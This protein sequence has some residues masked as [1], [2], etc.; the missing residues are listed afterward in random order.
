MPST[1]NSRLWRASAT[2][3]FAAAALTACSGGN[4]LAPTPVPSPPV[5]PPP[6][7]PPTGDTFDIDG[8]VTK[9]TVLGGAVRI[10]DPAAPETVLATGETSETDGSYDVVIPADANFS[11]DF[12]KVIVTGQDGAEMV[13][14]AAIG[15]ADAAFGETFPIDASFSLSAL[16]PAPGDGESDT[17]YVSALTDLAAAL[18]ESNAADGE[19]ST[20]LLGNA[21]QQVA[22]IFGLVSGDLTDLVPVDITGA[23]SDADPVRLRAALLN[24]GILAAAFEGDGDLGAVFDGLRTEFTDRGGQLIIN[25]ESDDPDVVSLRDILE[26]ASAAGGEVAFSSSAL[27]EARSGVQ[28]D[29]ATARASRPGTTTGGISSPS[30]GLSDLDQAKA[31]VSD[32]QLIVNAVDASETIDDFEAFADRID[33]AAAA[34]EDDGEALISALAEGVEAASEAYNAFIDDETTTTFA[35]NNG[36]TVDV[37]DGVDGVILTITDAT[38]GEE[39]L[40]LSATFDDGLTTTSS[41]ENGSSFF[42]DEETASG[43]AVIALSGQVANSNAALNIASGAIRLQDVDLVSTDESFFAET[44]DTTEFAVADLSAD[45]NIE[46]GSTAPDGLEFDGVLSFGI[47]GLETSEGLRLLFNEDF[48]IN[49]E[50]ASTSTSLSAAEFAFSG[51]V[52]E[53]GEFAD[54]TLFVDATA[55]NF[56]VSSEPDTIVTATYEVAPDG[57]Q[58]DV[59]FP[60]NTNG[61]TYTFTF[62]S[63]DEV[64]AELAR[65]ALQDNGSVILGRD[66]E[67]AVRVVV[68]GPSSGV[69]LNSE[70][71]VF[72]FLFEGDTFSSQTLFFQ[73]ESARTVLNTGFPTA[74]FLENA[75]Y[76]DLLAF[77]NG[78]FGDNDDAE[79]GCVDDTIVVFPPFRFDPEA[80]E[81]IGFVLFEDFLC[82]AFNPFDFEFAFFTAGSDGDQVDADATGEALLAASIR[83][84]I[85][86]LDADDPEVEF[87]AFGNVAVAD[88]EVT[89]DARL[90][91]SFAGRRF[92]TDARSFDVF[93]DLSTPVTVTNQDGLVL[94]LSEDANGD[95]TGTIVKGET[96]LG[97]I[98]EDSSGVVIVTFSDNSFVSLL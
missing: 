67:G 81:Q 80:T 71:P 38:I 31:F 27:D 1:S 59:Q 65:F 36:I 49:A 69:S 58:V 76:T 46:L 8:V 62:V 24:A 3:L 15:C 20:E 55:D 74:E 95:L 30:G 35:A 85:V 57:S 25:E 16:I 82:S 28:G 5:T 50:G 97:T 53:G 14:D 90:R 72:S 43:S 44:N 60:L 17:V 32:L 34:L 79:I 29:T 70:L 10:V 89:G 56:T 42:I 87:A 39:S 23:E 21:N 75:D 12:V 40:S 7:P 77:W 66:G 88:G 94:A 2:A 64:N 11:G 41:S 86:G 45:L 13:C 37:A 92:E 96:T 6:P 51:L 54:L 4:S 52:G 26:G 83:Q 63:V 47:L 61:L 91:I 48:S 19:L 18:A 78:A 93:E 33:T 9:G 73:A 98:S 68:P 84:D 22:D